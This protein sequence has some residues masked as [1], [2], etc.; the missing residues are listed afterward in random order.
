MPAQSLLSAEQATPQDSSSHYCWLPL[1]EENLGGPDIL[2]IHRPFSSRYLAGLHLDQAI[3]VHGRLI[4]GVE[5]GDALPAS[6]GGQGCEAL[7][8]LNTFLRFYLL[9]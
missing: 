5:K 7:H 3:V 4:R 6:A 8:V 9:V 1:L 2:V